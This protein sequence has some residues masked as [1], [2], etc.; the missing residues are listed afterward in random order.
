MDQQPADPDPQTPK[1]RV[2]VLVVHGVGDQAPYAS[3]RHIA[4]LLQS[5]PTDYSTFREIDLH[6]PVQSIACHAAPSTPTTPRL[7]GPIYELFKG[8]LQ[9]A[10]KRRASVA[11][12]PATPGETGIDQAFLLGQL[13]K[14]TPA[15]PGDMYETVRLEGCRGSQQQRDV[16]IYEMYWSDLS[17]LGSGSLRVLGELFQLLFHVSWLGAITTSA[18]A[19]QYAAS[20]SWAWFAKWQNAASL[21]LSVPIPLLNVLLFVLATATAALSGIV[22]F[23]NRG[24]VIGCAFFT[25]DAVSLGVWQINQSVVAGATLALIAVGL[26][27]WSKRRAAQHRLLFTVIP[28]SAFALFLAALFVTYRLE[29]IFKDAVDWLLGIDVTLVLYLATVALIRRYDRRRPG[30]FNLYLAGSAPVVTVYAVWLWRCA[31]K[32]GSPAY[33][34]FIG[35]LQF[36]EFIFAAIVLG[37]VVFGIL[38]LGS[39]CL[40]WLA[41]RS[42]RGNPEERGRGA[43]AN[44]TAR[45]TL[46]LSALLFSGTTIT[47]WAALTYAV[48]RS[49][50]GDVQY[51]PPVFDRMTTVTQTIDWLFSIAGSRLVPYLSAVL[52]LAFLPTV[53]ALW[54]SVLDELHAPANSSKAQSR[55]SG[56]WLSSG[57]GLMR[58]SGEIVYFGMMLFLAVQGYF[59]AIGAWHMLARS[60]PSLNQHW[61][62]AAGL[63][64]PLNSM[65]NFLLDRHQIVNSLGALVAGAGT[66]IILL[67]SRLNRFSRGFRPVLRIML[68]VDNWLREYPRES[69][70]TARI[71]ARYTSLLRYLAGWRSQENEQAGYD[72]LVIVAHSQGTVITVDL[73]R[74]LTAQGWISPIPIRLFTMGSPLRQLYSLRFPHL[75]EWARCE[76]KGPRCALPDPSRLGVHQWVNAYRSGD[77]VGRSLWETEENSRVWDPDAR[78]HLGSRDGFCIGAGAHMHYWDGTSA[79]ILRELDS[80]IKTA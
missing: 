22:Q 39:G 26:G 61:L 75:Y 13:E 25:N 27:Y 35:S 23:R 49:I 9:H 64:A 60:Y 40:G 72:A 10:V 57:F 42:L 16:H 33:A 51:L 50:C 77:Y 19:T 63:R 46:A 2:A 54:P 62:W 31:A 79:A 58:A 30:T 24:Q 20:R 7:R 78:F 38:Y 56:Y 74:F 37:W 65:A 45:L 59:L 1:R 66:G 48:T 29:L 43:R 70:P 44:F 5:D 28:L 80:L 67:G 68:D 8:R 73:L 17:R 4:R 21:V 41:V 15:K 36:L 12:K 52:V 32:P 18:A 76:D 6:I 11:G 47:L 71:C 34:L 14:S 53:W 3:S 55:F 69:N